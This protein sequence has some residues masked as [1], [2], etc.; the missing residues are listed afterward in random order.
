MAEVKGKRDPIA[1]YELVWRAEDA[2]V[3]RHW[4][5]GRRSIALAPV[6]AAG[7]GWSLAT[8]TRR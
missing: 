7:H 3:M 6:A 2:T 5:P 8:G 1:I 4:R